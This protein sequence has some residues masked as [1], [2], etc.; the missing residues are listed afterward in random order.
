MTLGRV[1]AHKLIS[2]F[3]WDPRILP[4]RVDFKDGNDSFKDANVVITTG[5]KSRNNIQSSCEGTDSSSELQVDPGS[6]VLDCK[7]CG[8]SVG[9]WA[10]STI[11]RPLEY[12]RFVG[13]TEVTG[14][15]IVAHDEAGAQEGSGN[16]ICAEKSRGGIRDAGSSASTSLGFTIAGGPPPALLNYGATISLP[17]VGQNLRARLPII[18]GNK[19]HSDVQSA[20]QV[21]D[22]HV[23][24][25]N[26]NVSAEE[27][28]ATIEPD[29]IASKPSEVPEYVAEDSNLNLNLT[30]TVKGINSVVSDELSISTPQDITSIRNGGGVETHRELMSENHEEVGRSDTPGIG[31]SQTHKPVLFSTSKLIHLSNFVF[32]FSYIIWISFFFLGSC[33]FSHYVL[34]ALLVISNSQYLVDLYEKGLV[35]DMLVFPVQYAMRI[36]L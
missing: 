12:I 11:P 7:L 19:D 22:Q 31:A 3:G 27:T 25:Q 35:V 13:L 9:L 23:S 26:E 4:Y 14:K 30:E 36:C 28:V 34:D 21:E 10:F 8:A 18:T 32:Q 15:N 5:Q 24:Q 6:V 1:Q 17:I 16:Q 29:V 20:S 2:L 33:I